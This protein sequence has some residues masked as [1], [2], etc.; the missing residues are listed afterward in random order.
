[1]K[2]TA[3]QQIRVGSMLLIVV[4]HCVCYYGIWAWRFPNALRFESIVYWKA[5]CNIALTAFV[6]ISG[7]LYAK[8]YVTKEKYRNR[9]LLLKD[10]MH[11][12]LF[13]YLIWSS[14]AL[15]LF[16]SDHLL[17]DLVSGVQHLWF[18]LMLMSIFLLV[19]GLG[20]NMLKI[21]IL[22]GGVFY[23]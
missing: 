6:F 11:R 19:I 13:P 3:I 5:I 12:L 8:L 1:M 9:K 21:R 7:L 23:S 18:L 20:D 22:M 14:L 16:P 2:D 10:K 17:E 4:Y 15:L